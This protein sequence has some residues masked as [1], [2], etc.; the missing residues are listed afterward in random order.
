[1]NRRTILGTVGSGTALLLAGCSGFANPFVE[2]DGPTHL[3]QVGNGRDTAHDVRVDL[4][5]DGESDEYGPRTVEPGE[6]WE[7][8]RIEHQVTLTV[9][10]HVDDELVWEDTHEVPTPGAGR[11]SFTQLELLPDDEVR[12]EVIQED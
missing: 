8:R 5:F 6:N 2:S 11:K 7:V 10:V 9:R 4:T 3:V 1:M 12:T